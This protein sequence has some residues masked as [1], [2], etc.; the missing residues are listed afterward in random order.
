M[1][2]LR[3][4]Q[5]IGLADITYKVTLQFTKCF[6]LQFLRFKLKQFYGIQLNNYITDIR[7]HFYHKYASSILSEQQ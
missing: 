4:L 6:I 3:I 2:M 7:T 5:L 1:V